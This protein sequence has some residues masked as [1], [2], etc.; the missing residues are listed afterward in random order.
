M[1]RVMAKIQKKRGI[2]AVMVFD[3][4]DCLV[5][6]AV[7]KIFAFGPVLQIRQPPG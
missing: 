3:K 2:T 7:G 5:G 6:Y 1:D 4:P